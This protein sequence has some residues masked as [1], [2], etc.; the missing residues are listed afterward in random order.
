MLLRQDLYHLSLMGSALVWSEK[1]MI[2]YFLEGG[3]EEY[4]L[5]LRLG[6]SQHLYLWNWSHG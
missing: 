1:G 4:C 3:K 2:W 6:P 5:D